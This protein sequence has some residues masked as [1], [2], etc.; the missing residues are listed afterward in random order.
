MRH[1][2]LAKVSRHAGFTLVE[3][4]VVI[5]IIGMLVGLLLPAVQQAREAARQT[6]CNNNLKNM[7]IAAQ[8]HEAEMGFLPSGGWYYQ[9]YGDADCGLGCSQPGA[10]TYSILPFVEQEALYMKCADGDKENIS[11]TQK[12]NCLTVAQTPLPLF[13]CPS[14]RTAKNYTI[15]TSVQNC[16]GLSTGAKSDY[17][18]NW[19]SS[20]ENPRTEVGTE[21]T[22]WTTMRDK[23]KSYS[24]TQSDATGSV[25][26]ASELPTSAIEDGASNTFFVGEKYL[27]PN[28]YETS[29]STD[30]NG[31]YA[32]HDY[33]NQRSAGTLSNNSTS[34]LP[35]AD[36][37]GFEPSSYR[38]GSAHAS[39]VG[40][41]MCDGSVK[42]ISY[43][44]N[45][46]TW[47][48]LA[49]RNDGRPVTAP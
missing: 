41:A 43:S 47:M 48:C 1:V 8:S 28:I 34:R 6:Q 36:R 49:A 5:A 44:I 32:G 38:F 20:S 29:S 24:W 22:G 26:Y 42:R 21:N 13:N 37:P 33:D 46:I 45:N 25:F 14:R 27:D 18:G 40:M 30:D 2:L 23:V 35:M 3:L 12:S 11:A 19:G 7:S 31:L 4:L 17:A 9:F 16:N 15:S 39:G 10:W